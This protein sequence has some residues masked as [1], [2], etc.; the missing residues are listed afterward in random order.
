MLIILN[1]S[2]NEV[3]GRRDLD[4]SHMFYMALS[5]V[6]K[7][8]KLAKRNAAFAML[9]LL[10]QGMAMPQGDSEP[11]QELDEDAIPLVS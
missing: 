3:E 7:S 10:K 4:S 2:D 6:G 11:M 8:K 1:C 5:G 9:Q